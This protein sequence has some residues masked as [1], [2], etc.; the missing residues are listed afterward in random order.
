MSKAFP[1]TP[2]D[3]IQSCPT[4]H[5]PRILVAGTSSNAGK[6]TVTCAVLKALKNRGVKLAGFKCGPDYIDP[7]FHAKVMGLKSRNLD[8]VLQ[9][10]AGVRFLL[11]RSAASA[12]FSVIEGVMG[13]YDG[14]GMET[15]E[16]S[17]NHIACLT[18]T[19]EVLV[20]DVYGM[21]LSAAAL[22]HGYL[23][24]R[25]NLIRGVIFNRCP[26]SM[27]PYYQRMVEEQLGLKSYG[28]LPM[29]PEAAL[30]SRH[31]GLVTAEEIEH[32]SLKLDRL[33]DVASQTVDLDGLLALG[34]EAKPLLYDDLWQEAAPLSDKPIR[35]GIAKDKAFCFYY[36]DN[37]D[38]LERLGC[39]IVEF[40]P[41]KDQRLPENLSGLILPGGYPEIF[42]SE[43]A[44]NVGML[45]SV[46]Q[47]V[48]SGLP[49]LAE[50]GGFM[51]LLEGLFDTAGKTHGMTGV[52]SGA[53]WM[54]EGLVRFGYLSLTAKKD[55]LLLEAG[56]T[57]F[58]HEFHHSDSDANG[59]DLNAERKGN[60]WPCGHASLR[61]FAGYPHLHF[62]ANLRAARRFV[63]ACLGAASGE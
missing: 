51:Y 57:V 1:S 18:G 49:T 56:E 41:L 39:E 58:A 29:V 37:L 17:S 32:L 16:A 23:T 11:A 61:L 21:A 26:E 15:E 47:A 13:I 22:L 50:C 27:Y 36:Q 31:L 10:E 24:F 5:F 42:A 9:G 63:K 7:M 35:I 45:K 20:V 52:L 46:R 59:V 3:E 19:P 25:P 43:L 60:R 40:S 6:T 38:L 30:E 34:Q 14:L 8:L 48:L 33:A 54:T 28:F 4:G 44:A 2:V 55:N 62:G 12:D 53:S